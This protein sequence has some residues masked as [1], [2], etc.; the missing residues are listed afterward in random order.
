MGL[1]VK[2]KGGTDFQ[3][4]DAGVHHAVC[5]GMIDL[6]HQYNPMYNKDEHKIMIMWELPHE[7]I[8]IDGKDLPRAISRKFTM[9]LSPKS[10]LRPFLESWRS[11]PFT[12]QQLDDGWDI[13]AIIGANCQLSIIHETFK[14]KAGKDKTVAKISAVMPLPKG[15]AKLKTETEEQYFSFEDGM[16]VP[17]NLPEW[18]KEIIHKSSELNTEN[19]PPPEKQPQKQAEDDSSIPF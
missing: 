17:E 15:T 10:N 12:N 9:S 4:V 14:D 8:Q 2:S 19:L 6:G 7:R 18:V 5:Y 1:M 16:D 3:P 11:Q 13:K